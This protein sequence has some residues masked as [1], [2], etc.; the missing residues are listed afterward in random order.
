[1]TQRPKAKGDLVRSPRA[2]QPN[3]VRAIP[4]P[5]RCSW[6]APAERSGDGAFARVKVELLGEERRLVGKRR[7]ASLPAAVQAVVCLTLLL[8]VFSHPPRATSATNPP[9]AAVWD[10]TAQ[11]TTGFGYSDNV[12]RSSVAPESSG[13]YNV[14]ADASFIRFAESG[15][16][17]TFFVLGDYTKY[18]DAPSVGYEEL[19]SGTAQ[20]VTPL[21]SQD[22]LGGEFSYLYQ[23]QVVDVS[24]TEAV[25]T[26]MLV[27]G[28]TYTV[29]PYWKHTL[30]P[31]WAVQLEVEGLRQLYGE[32]LSD[33]WETATRVSLIHKYSHRSEVSIGYQ[34][35]HIWY[36]DREQF[37]TA[38]VAIPGTSL[39][40]WQHEIGA[41][42][43]HHWDEAR[44]WRTTTKLSYLFNQDNGSGYFDY[45]RVLFSE[46]LRW[47]NPVWEIKGGVRVG[48]YYY[49]VQQINN[50]QL[51]RSYVV[52]DLR[53]E[54]RLGKHWLLYLNAE[55]EWSMS[56]DPVEE[57]NDW[58]AGGGAGFEF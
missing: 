5:Q 40:Y 18:F 42:W 11:V 33:Y 12:M 9:V 46:Q 16:Y 28:H 37:D 21:G 55:R 45:N 17:L 43:R 53:I 27:N 39:Y 15:A 20:A 26:R 7:G 31:A 47:T 38:G 22:E 1:M 32:D 24:E 57:Y 8:I 56:N 52:V 4:A 34:P 25:L 41:Q 30:S 2:I 29:R 13:F 10:N 3:K 19:F 6:T 23:H 35:K 36:D 14:S 50:E 49:P 58:L 51:E 48:W 44:H 54:R